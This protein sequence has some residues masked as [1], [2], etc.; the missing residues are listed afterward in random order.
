VID[1]AAEVCQLFGRKVSIASGAELAAHWGVASPSGRLRLAAW[2]DRLVRREVL[3]RWRVIARP[4]PPP[5][6][7]LVTFRPGGPIADANAVAWALEKRWR[8]EP[9][10]V[11]A[12]AGG[13]RCRQLFGAHVACGLGNLDAVSHDLAL[14]A[15][16]FRFA[17]FSPQRANDWVADWERKSALRAGEKLPDVLLHAADGAPYLAVEMGG[18]YSA[19][20]VNGLRAF[21][22]DSLQIPLE[23][24]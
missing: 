19:T 15:L 21:C 8:V 9:Q 18:V 2:L 10:V 1:R 20:R 6:A 22:T 11:V 7:P 14:A 5:A 12:Y 17:R 24:W 3:L 23:V 13:P 16:Y 4:L